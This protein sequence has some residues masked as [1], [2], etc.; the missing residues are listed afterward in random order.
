HALSHPIGEITR[1]GEAELCFPF[2]VAGIS[3]VVGIAEPLE[4]RVFDAAAFF[5]RSFGSENRLGP[6][7]KVETIRAFR[8]AETG[9]SGGVLR[10]IEHDEFSGI[11]SRT[12]FVWNKCDR[13]IEGAA[14]FP[15]SAL[16]VK[17]RSVRSPCPYAKGKVGSLLGKAERNHENAEQEEGGST[18]WSQ[19]TRHG[20]SVGPHGLPARF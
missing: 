13:R 17:N 12:I 15:S 18:P 2:V 7:R 19:K 9:G 16:R 10:A 20:G 6:A 11:L 1:C 8:V 4:A 3:Q 5:V 14:R